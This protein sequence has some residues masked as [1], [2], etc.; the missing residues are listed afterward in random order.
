[1]TEGDNE[2]IIVRGVT[3]VGGCGD[4]EPSRRRRESCLGV[5]G[6]SEG[7]RETVWW[8]EKGIVDLEERWGVD[9]GT[10]ENCS[11]PPLNHNSDCWTGER[12]SWLS[13]GSSN[14]K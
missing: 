14:P 4:T 5:W 11:P 8:L 1:M 12:G 9:T 13:E 6:E 7:D 10:G 3:N 2:A